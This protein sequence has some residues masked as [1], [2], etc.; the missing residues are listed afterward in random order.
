MRI[1][2]VRVLFLPDYVHFF[3]YL[4]LLRVIHALWS[5]SVCQ[6]LPPEVRAAM[7][8]TD[9]ERNSLL[10]EPKTK[11]SKGASVYADGSLDGTQEGKTEDIRNWLKGIRESG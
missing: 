5:P 6:T 11:S 1:D 8:M 3:L 2:H 4:Q 7:T 10:G 9:A